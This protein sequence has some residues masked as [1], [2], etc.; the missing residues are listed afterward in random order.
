MEAA[1]EPEQVALG[2]DVAVPCAFAAV[3]VGR[4]PGEAVS[5]ANA[6]R[7][8]TEARRWFLTRRCRAAVVL[9]LARVTGALPA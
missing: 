8:P 9:P 1:Q 4:A 6:Q 3:V 5:A 2:G 7:Y